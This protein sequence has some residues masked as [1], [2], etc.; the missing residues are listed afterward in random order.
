MEVLDPSLE[1]YASLWREEIARRF[2]DAV[3]VICHG[4]DLEEGRW[5]VRSGGQYIQTADALVQH[6][7]AKWPG[8][9]I[10]LL[11]CNPGH[12]ALHES[13]VYYAL[14]SVWCVP[15]RDT[16]EPDSAPGE[17][18]L[19]MDGDAVLGGADRWH[20]ESGVVGNIFEFVDAD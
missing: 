14:D 17:D 11:A 8:R 2:P 18:R 16:A 20:A 3:G 4:G 13:G 7:Q 15:D 10:V 19:T 1:S 5:V 12:L 9:V 6:F